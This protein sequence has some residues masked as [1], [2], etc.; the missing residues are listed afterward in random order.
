[1]RILISAG[2]ASGEFYGAELIKALRGTI[3]AQQNVEFFG[4]GGEQMRAAGCQIL[5]EA[6]EI[7]EVGIVE[8]VKHIPTIYRRFRQVVQAVER[9]RPD[10]AVL[11]DFPD[12]NLRLARELHKRGVPVIYYV[13]PQLWAWKQSRV[14]RVR[15]Y[16]RKMLV[17]FPFEEA[18]YRDH[19]IEAQFVGH[20]LA[21]LPPPNITR[22]QFAAEYKLDPARPWIALLPGSRRGEVSRIFPVLLQAAQLLG[23]DYVYT[24]PIAS[25]LD[26]AWMRSFLRHYSGPP[27]TFTRE[28]PATLQHARVAAVAS[29]TSTLEAALIGTPFAMVYR[30][31]PLTWMLGRR[32]VKVDRFAMVNLIAGRDVVA[33][34]VQSNFTPQRVTA[35]LRRILPDGAERE[36]MLSGFREVRSRLR[37]GENEGAASQRA[38]QAVL[39][40]MELTS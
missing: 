17:I 4:V 33:E 31:A 23:P 35:E 8:V 3:P 1:M 27:I 36:A 22:E 26:P 9:Q 14:E 37:P 5:V 16:V 10:V 40:A 2:E 28:A 21:D 20:P 11:I 30:V 13:S 15:R 39:C 12:F 38:A 25:T 6:K 18:F 7:A 32:L 29:G 34:L 19:G 24:V